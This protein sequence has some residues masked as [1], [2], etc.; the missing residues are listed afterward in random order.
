MYK[1][2]SYLPLQFDIFLQ[3]EINIIQTK[4]QRLRNDPEKNITLYQYFSKEMYNVIIINT[5][6]AFI[7]IQ[8]TNRYVGYRYVGYG[9]VNR[10]MTPNPALPPSV[11]CARSLYNPPPHASTI[12]ITM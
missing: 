3:L 1:D 11:L 9:S 7:L 2:C 6:I 4:T 12:W 10:E 5:I 8:A